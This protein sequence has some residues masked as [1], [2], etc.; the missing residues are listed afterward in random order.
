MSTSIP[1]GL[2]IER[3][4]VELP[5]ENVSVSAGAGRGAT[6]TVSLRYRA[7][8]SRWVLNPEPLAPGYRLRENDGKR[9]RTA[10]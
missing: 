8:A 10:G 3:R 6:F 5:V 9:A 1:I 2:S 7:A 4:L